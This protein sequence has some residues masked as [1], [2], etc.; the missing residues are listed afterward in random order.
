MRDDAKARGTAVL[1]FRDVS[2]RFAGRGV[3]RRPDAVRALDGVSLEVM[4]GETLTI[5]GESGSGKSTLGRIGTRL[6]T[7]HNGRVEI[8]GADVSDAAP[9]PDPTRPHR[10]HAAPP[11]TTDAALRQVADTHWVAA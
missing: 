3:F 9:V 2:R 6:D 5:V 7:E 11:A 10:P 4:P 1:A 8:D